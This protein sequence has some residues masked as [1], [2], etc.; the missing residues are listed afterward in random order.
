MMYAVENLY[1][2]T[3]LLPP[4]PSPSMSSYLAA[5]LSGTRSDQEE[6]DARIPHSKVQGT[7]IVAPLM[8]D[9]PESE[10]IRQLAADDTVTVQL[11]D[12]HYIS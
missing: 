7:V 11:V 2:L 4:S 12:N 6:E 10:S 8:T 5:K 9:A 1:K 3:N